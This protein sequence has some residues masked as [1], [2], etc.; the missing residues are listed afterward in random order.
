MGLN[1]S[2][3]SCLRPDRP[4][5][6]LVNDIMRLI[7]R[8]VRLQDQTPAICPQMLGRRLTMFRTIR[9]RA[10]FVGGCPYYTPLPLANNMP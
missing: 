8:D 4:R 3:V 9:I 7:R 10:G 5:P 2:T 1:Q 6:I